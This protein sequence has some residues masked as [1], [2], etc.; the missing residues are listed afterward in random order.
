MYARSLKTNKS[1]TLGVVL[2]NFHHSSSMI[3][4]DSIHALASKH[5]FQTFITEANGTE[6]GEGLAIEAFHG[7]RV[8]GIVVGTSVANGTRHVIDR[9]VAQRTPVVLVG[10]GTVHQNIDGVMIDFR[11]GGKMAALHL[12]QLGHKRIAFLGGNLKNAE[13]IPQLQGYLDALAEA[14]LPVNEK[15]VIGEP[16]HLNGNISE[17][18][19]F[20]TASQLLQGKIRPTAIV[21]QSDQVAF[22]VMHAARNLGLSIPQDLSLVGFG[23]SPLASEMTPALTTICEPFLLQGQKAVSLILS[24]IQNLNEP[25]EPC[26]VTLACELIRRASVQAIPT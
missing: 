17:V 1:T 3:L 15:D 21:A 23:D 26:Q 7:Q 6:G 20:R 5:G 14:G 22:G 11:S 4:A 18:F 24:R 12:I 19:G 13:T 2:R 9:I 16:D 8:A 25:Q 10:D